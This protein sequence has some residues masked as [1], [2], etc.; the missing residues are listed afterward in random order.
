MSVSPRV[1]SILTGSLTYPYHGVG[2]ESTEGRGV[3]PVYTG[4]EGDHVACDRRTAGSLALARQDRRFL[5]SLALVFTDTVLLTAATILATLV[6][7]GSIWAAS[8]TRYPGI[9]S[10]QLSATAVIL[11][12][13][14]LRWQHLYHVNRL[15][16]GSGEFKRLVVGLSAGTAC[17]VF[18][19]YVLNIPG[20]SRGWA[21]LT[22]V[23][24]LV[25]VGSVRLA[26]RLFV[27]IMRSRDRL[28]RPTLIVGANEEATEI[29]RIL[30]KNQS[31]GLVPIGYVTSSAV[32]TSNMEQIPYLGTAA[33]LRN[34][35]RSLGVDT[36]LFASSAFD[37]DDLA[38]MVDTLRN[39][40]VQVQISSRLLDV[41]TSRVAMYEVNGLPIIGIENR[42]ATRI[43]AGTKRALDLV[44]SSLLI[45]LSAP[46]WLFIALAIKVTSRGPVLYRQQRVGENGRL[47]TM[48]K[49]RSMVVDAHGRRDEFAE[50]N[51]SSGPL[52]KIREDPRVT[53]VGRVLRR[54]SL[55][56]LP[57]LIN[58]FM[59]E[60]SLVGPRPALPLEVAQYEDHHARRLEALPGMTGLWQVSG[61]SDLTFEEM[62]R[63]DLFYIENWSLTLDLSLLARTVPAVVSARGSY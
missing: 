33:G 4:V 24:A 13:I 52:F 17:L 7:F 36:V 31:S 39:D 20:M 16:L 43:K 27:R 35:V 60:M 38:E 8:V 34:L 30:R 50:D 1:V 59:G 56:E 57:Q 26:R 40:D 2:R 6:R 45:L 47:F 15:E 58:V 28:L 48:L 46:F 49:F 53:P 21:L 41:L 12:V 22:W 61:R 9:G 51:E 5:A 19:T 25:L 23:F 63:L 54:C 14:C 44:L 55:D 37:Y 62:V 29:V 10:I 18:V 3:Q 42:G 11:W 32:S